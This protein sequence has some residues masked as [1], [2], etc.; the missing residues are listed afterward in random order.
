MDTRVSQIANA[1]GFEMHRHDRPVLTRD[2]GIEYIMVEDHEMVPIIA[3]A[4]RV[5]HEQAL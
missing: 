4:Q 3:A 5:V 1:I 2:D